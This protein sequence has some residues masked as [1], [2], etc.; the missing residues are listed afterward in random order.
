MK[1]NW[2]RWF[3][4]KL[5]LKPQTADEVMAIIREFFSN[6]DGAV[7]SQLHWTIRFSQRSK[8][9]D[10]LTA[11]R[12]PDCMKDNHRIKLATTSVIRSAA[13]GKD[14]SMREYADFSQLDTAANAEF[15]LMEAHLIEDSYHFFNHARRAF[16]ALGLKWEKPNDV[17]KEYTQSDLPNLGAD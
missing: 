14:S 5:L 2:K 4:R 13:L 12:G 17:S 15:R 3:R 7:T 8:L 10:I 6:E 11:L 1:L 16:I 9:W